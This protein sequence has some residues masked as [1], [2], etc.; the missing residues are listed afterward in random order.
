MGFFNWLFGKR[1]KTELEAP[2]A[3]QVYVTT[4]ASQADGG[5]STVVIS[6]AV[7][8]VFSADTNTPPL[9]S[10]PVANI[11][12]SAPGGIPT[13]R[14]ADPVAVANMESLMREARELPIGSVRGHAVAHFKVDARGGYFLN[15]KRVSLRK[16]K[17]ECVRLEKIGGFVFYYREHP[18]EDPPRKAG[19]VIAAICEA[20]LP[21]TFAGRDY[22][23][24]VKVA[25][26][27]LPTGAW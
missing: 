11:L 8:P 22:D 1:E 10:A 19:A 4:D 7:G 27:L 25:E 2:G 5:G 18:G 16:L 26:Y 6:P 21:L 3:S 20:R 23:P 17:K 13:G 15:G 12:D 24:K 14:L 9:A